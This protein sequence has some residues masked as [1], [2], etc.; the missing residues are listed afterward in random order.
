M[1]ALTTQQRRMLDFERAWW[2]FADGTKPAAIRTQFGMT[3]AAYYQALD[4]FIFDDDA[5]AHDRP[6]VQ[7]LRRLAVQRQRQ[8]ARR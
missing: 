5:L 7:R 1:T 8:K 3:V 6:L 4:R 2:K